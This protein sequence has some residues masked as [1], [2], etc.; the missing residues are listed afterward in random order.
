MKLTIINSRAF[1]YPNQCTP[2]GRFF[3]VYMDG[4]INVN[5]N[6]EIGNAIPAKVWHGVIRRLH[7]PDGY[8]RNDI[9]AF[10]SKHRK[11]FATLVKGMD[12][13]WNNSN[14]VGTL[15]DDAN[16]A[17]ESLSYALYA[18][19]CMISS[20]HINI[21]EPP[22]NTLPMPLVIT[23]HN[24]LYLPIIDALRSVNSTVETT[25]FNHMK[26]LWSLFISYPIISLAL[27]TYMILLSIVMSCSLTGL[28]MIT[29]IYYKPSEQRFNLDYNSP[30]TLN[31]SLDASTNT[32]TTAY[33]SS[34]ELRQVIDCVD[35]LLMPKIGR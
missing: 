25:Q 24:D 18:E 31:T 7:I 5:V 32:N 23:V 19:W 11:E 16:K 33:T 21:S 3:Q 17:L 27:I 29:M 30:N 28:E 15:T 26:Q 9:K 13:E 6:Y 34:R 8:T 35:E 22:S 14:Y 1:T 2:Q 20:L 10:Y 4:T 12:S